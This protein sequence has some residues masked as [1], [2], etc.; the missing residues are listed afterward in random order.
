M[1]H[2]TLHL[3]E[4]SAS[5]LPLLLVVAL[6]FLVPILLSR[7]RALPVVVGE[8][9][10]GILIG[11]VVLG[12]LTHST[13]LDFMGNIGLTFL[14]FLAGLE[15]DLQ[16]LL[17][18]RQ[19]VQGENITARAGLIYLFTMLLALPAGYALH[20]LGLDAH[21]VLISFILSATSL[22]VLL[23]ILKEN[24]LL[25]R[26][27]GQMVFLAA[28]LADFLTVI[29]FTVYVLTQDHGFSLEILSLGLLFLVSLVT[30][31]FAP[32]FV[33]IPRIQ[34]LFNDLSSVTVQIKVRGALALMLAFVVLAEAVNAELILGA[35]LAG[36]IISLMRVPD[37][38][39][40]VHNLEA[41]GFGFF[42]PIF[43]IQ[44][45]AN[46]K[47]SALFQEPQ[48]LLLLPVMLVFSVLVKGLPMLALR[49]RFAWRDVL[50]GGLLLNTHLSLEVAVV[51]I[52]ESIGLVSPAASAA[53]ILFSVLTVVLMPLLFQALRPVVT[54]ITY[55]LNVIVGTHMTARQVAETLSAHGDRVCFLSED[56]QAVRELQQAGY[57]VYEAPPD[58]YD[59]STLEGVSALLL[60]TQND[61]E[62][63]QIDRPTR[64]RRR[65]GQYPGTPQRPE[66]S[67]RFPRPGCTGLPAGHSRNY[68]AGADGAQPRPIFAHVFHARWPRCAGS[69]YPQ[70]QPVRAKSARPSPAAYVPGAFAA[71]RQRSYHPARQHPSGI[72]RQTDLLE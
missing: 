61:D 3:A 51:V 24:D 55:N 7:L 17:N 36:M 20:A 60:L 9:L 5:F 19:G 62:N 21:P 52:G 53:V 15:I 54:H 1:P 64:P 44:V 27:Y 31:R 69:T 18:K 6:A 43:F 28:T 56:P 58:E 40:L 13:T 68:P 47:L 30:M 25:G 70:P 66:T 49:P 10:A 71:P 63:L 39:S 34:R 57:T 11:P 42:I 46:L 72:R 23:P 65:P 45:G 33:R 48:L 37:D 14:M 8:I 12:W 38:T 29:L 67:A 41:F 16:S 26:P 22:G 50:S 32:P 59:F 35:F 2:F 4:Q